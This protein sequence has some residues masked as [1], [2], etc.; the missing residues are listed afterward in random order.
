MCTDMLL[1]ELVPASRIASVTFLAHGAV[2]ITHPGVDRG[3]AVNH[4]AAE[5]IVAERP[6][7]IFASE[8]STPIAKRLALRVGAPLIEVKAVNS[9]ADI[10]AVTRQMAAAVGEAVRG[11]AMIADMDGKLAWLAAHP[12]ARRYTVAAWSGGSVPGR[13]TLA[14]EIIED[15]GAVN[16]A[17]KSNGADYNTFGIEELLKADPDILIYGDDATTSPALH[18][19]S[20]ENP[21]VRARWAGRTVTYPE[22]LFSCGVPQ[23]ADAAILLRRAFDRVPPRPGA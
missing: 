3:V 22:A 14:N 17:S 19:L 1:L 10:R 20:L 4:G 2:A 18:R 23:S 21:A 7:L 6:D 12:P 9:F 16:I 13:R 5:D 8:I 15:A 11:E